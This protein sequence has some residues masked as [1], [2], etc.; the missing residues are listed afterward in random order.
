MTGRLR[1]DKES[2]YNILNIGPERGMMDIRKIDLR[3]A[4][5]RSGGVMSTRGHLQNPSI[6]PKK[7]E[8]PHH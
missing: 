5:I 7:G 1:K 4:T 3:D 2:V 8:P 6:F